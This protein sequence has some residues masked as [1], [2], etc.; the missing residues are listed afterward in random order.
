MNHGTVRRRIN[1]YSAALLGLLVALAAAQSLP[2]QAQNQAGPAIRERGP[3]QRFV[4]RLE[5][6]RLG[7]PQPA[8]LAYS[9]AAKSFL[10]LP[11]TSSAAAGAA[12]ANFSVV[13][14]LEEPAGPARVSAGIADALNITFDSANNR[15]LAFDAAAGRIT[16]VQARATGVPD[17]SAAAVSRF[18]VRALGVKAPQGIAADASNG[19]VYILDGAELVFVEPGAQQSLDG[20]AAVREGR[21]A[22]ID[23]RPA[24]LGN[25]RGIAFNPA[26]EHLY[27]L[28]PGRR[29][30]YELTSAG[31]LVATRDLRAVAIR[32]AQGMAFAPSGDNSDSPDQ[33][34][35]YI[36]DAGAAGS[37]VE[38]SLTQPELRTTAAVAAT[39]PAV[40]IHTINANQWS[41]NSPDPMGLGY[42]SSIGRL[43]ESDSEVEEMP[44][45]FTGKNMFY[46]TV[47]GSLTGT[48]SV[49]NFS[50]EPTGVAFNAANGHIFISDDDADDVFEI[51]A[52]PD[53]N[54]FT[55][56]D[57]RT[58]F[59]TRAISNMDAE[60]V[61]FDS[62]QGHLYIADGL[63]S[64]VWRI[65][66]GNNGRFDG[67]PPAGDDVATHFDSSSLGVSDPEGI[68]YNPN[69]GH[70]YLVGHGSPVVEMT[71]S[72]SVI[73]SIDV[74]AFVVAGSGLAMA[75][76]SV[77]S[78]V[79]A[80]YIS[81]R[82]EDNDGDP[83]END[84]KIHE[85]S[86]GDGP[87]GPTNT[88]TN[89]PNV[90][91]TNT[92]TSTPTPIPSNAN[93][94]LSL[95][96]NG[97]AGG[98]TASDE[99]ILRFNQGLFTIAFDGSDVGISGDID[100]FTFLDS[101]TILFS[102]EATT[103]VGALGSVDSFDIIQFDASSLGTTTA[104]TFSLYFDGSDVGLDSSSENIDAF[105]LLP[106]GRLLI[107]TS[108]SPAIA[109]LSSIAD[110]DILAFAPT[111]LGA[112]TAGSWSLYF[113]GSDVGLSANSGDIDELSVAANGD[114]YLSMRTDFAVGALAGDNSDVLIC[115]PTSLGANTACTFAPTLYFDGSVAGVSG[116]NLDGLGFPAATGGTPTNTPT[117][118]PVA[119][120]NTP[121]NTPV[122]PTNTPTNTPVGPTSTPTNTPVGPT[123]TPTS[124][125]VSGADLIFADSFESGN[126]SA[127]TASKVDTN[128]LSV[129]AAAALAGSRGMQALI[130]DS[131]T[132]Y[133]T[134]DTPNAEPRYRA[135][136]YFDPNTIAMANNDAHIMFYGYTG[137]STTMLR[138]EFRSSSGAYQ[139]RAGLKN[140][141]DAWL[142]TNYVTISD[143]PHAIEFD[144]RAATAAG[145]ND[146][147]LTFWIDGVQQGNLTGVDNDLARVD[148]ARLGPANSI[149]AGTRGT[150]YFD[151]FESRRQ[152]FI[153]P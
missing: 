18:D 152:S 8:G 76:S 89:T 50:N 104:G 93:F 48:A 16:A 53:G 122:A 67:P 66:P 49:T 142:S 62:T 110:E 147:G 36:A 86:L 103:T 94:F 19:G 44:N 4:R 25:V 6:H 35:L 134:D 20:A 38:L 78:S 102:L 28:N 60:G 43:L 77:N 132:L 124:T 11:P 138:I 27:V 114:L 130:N 136:F 40:L 81:D 106:D 42:I 101:D 143:A 127:W 70:L 120:T 100:A 84:G 72:G 141:A 145:A 92:P 22:R 21:A 26:D 74:S 73:R 3:Y 55:S 112:N 45:Y 153:G 56:D 150:Y 135:R 97:T 111:S 83:N 24:G 87:V 2:T 34:S 14:A 17:A 61:A 52:G 33:M 32:N 90:P 69:N 29:L 71:T 146:G 133:V 107:S 54:Y 119:P 9:P 31:Q 98:V 75:P 82:G 137:T 58:R 140:D 121:T 13:S 144:W 15:L 91:P 46:S 85:I 118:T 51:A 116:N 131:N 88:P 57:V 113:D 129:T 125:P 41:P 79:N 10:F 39:E 37:I 128:D 95:A 68:E 47:G 23:L 59:D 63:N 109:G 30:L 151:T 139:L 115:T 105:E 80:L 5:T 1:R 12:S 64:E 96:S 108:G 99:D 117:N 123:N 126:F 148:R 65:T 149:D 7:Y